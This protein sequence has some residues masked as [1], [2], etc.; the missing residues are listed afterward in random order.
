[1]TSNQQNTSAAPARNPLRYTQFALLVVA[2]MFLYGL[3]TG[4]LVFDWLFDTMYIL[5]GVVTALPAGSINPSQSS[6]SAL[7]VSA[8]TLRLILGCYLFVDSVL[9]AAMALPGLGLSLLVYTSLSVLYGLALL[10]YLRNNHLYISSNT[11]AKLFQGSAALVTLGA[12]ISLICLYLPMLWVHE[13]FQAWSGPVVITLPGTT[14]MNAGQTV[15]IGG[16]VIIRGYQV[17]LGH[18]PCLLLAGV[19]ILQVLK[20][21]GLGRPDHLRLAMRIAAVMVAVWWVFIA[22]AYNCLTMPLNL[23]FVAGCTLLTFAVFT[24]KP[25]D[26]RTE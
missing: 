2:I 13:G 10:S 9:L 11:W 26:A 14:Y 18:L 3:L 21:Q 25:A 7:P 12:L 16:N 22:K 23:L 1:M 6:A 8:G 15:N 4:R 17:R 20:I 5:A 24:G 19:G